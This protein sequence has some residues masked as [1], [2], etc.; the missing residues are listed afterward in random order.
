MSTTEN[1]GVKALHDTCT[2]MELI[3]NEMHSTQ[4]K[5]FTKISRLLFFVY[6]WKTMLTK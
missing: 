3:A 4:G 6:A 1:K 2:C 5:V